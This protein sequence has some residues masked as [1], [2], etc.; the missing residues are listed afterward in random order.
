[1]ELL[2]APFAQVSPEA[3]EKETDPAGIA[4]EAIQPIQTT[5]LM[6]CIAVKVAHQ[7]EPEVEFLASTPRDVLGADPGDE[8]DGDVLD[9][10]ASQ[11]RRILDTT[12]PDPSH[13]T[14]E[15]R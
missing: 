3:R 1:M 2:T 14:A 4:P 15:G 10:L 12:R 9:A 8:A 6:P 13:G 7:A 11:A 5:P